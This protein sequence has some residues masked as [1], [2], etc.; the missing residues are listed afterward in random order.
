MQP[1]Y[2]TRIT[3]RKSPRQKI[4]KFFVY[5]CLIALVLFLLDKFNFPSPKGD[6]KKNI[7]NEI[8]KLK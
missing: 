8:I 5:V 7:T 4:V 6:I 3:A 1:N 2:G